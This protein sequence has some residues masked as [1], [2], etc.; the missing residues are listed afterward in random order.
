[1]ED[2]CGRLTEMGAV[3]RIND[4]GRE[5]VGNR[6]VVKR[7]FAVAEAYTDIVPLK[8]N[9]DYQIW[10][11]VP[12]LDAYF[13]YFK[14]D[15]DGNARCDSELDLEFGK[16]RALACAASRASSQSMSRSISRVS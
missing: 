14:L 6:Y 15:C 9:S 3:A 2:Q 12:V 4:D 7:T 13:V 5:G 16:P 11:L 1:M 8:K 10:V